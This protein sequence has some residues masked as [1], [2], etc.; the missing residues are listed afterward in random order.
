MRR[1][2]VLILMLIASVSV[3]KEGSILPFNAQVDTLPNGLKIV[4]VPTASKGIIV[5]YSIVRAGSR[6]EVEAG[7]TGFAHF[8]EHMMFRGTERYSSAEWGAKLASYGADTNAYTTYDYTAYF[9]VAPKT[10]LADLITL[11]SDR[12]MNLKYS[13]AGFRTE[14]G[15]VLGE[16]NKAKSQP[17]MSIRE[18]LAAAAFKRHTYGHTVI[19]L[20]ADIKA[21]PEGFAYAQTFFER[22]YT[23]DNTTILVVGDVD[24]ATLLPQIE[25]AYGPWKRT[26]TPSKITPEPAQTEPRSAHV[27]WPTPTPVYVTVAW[28]T[29]AFSTESVDC[30]ALEVA[31]ELLYGKTSPLYRR[32]VLTEQSVLGLS[33]TGGWFSRDPG[34]L[35]I[36][37][38]LKDATEPESI[39]NAITAAAASLASG[40]IDEKQLAAVKS[41]LR[42]RRLM[43]LDSP[44]AVAEYFVELIG[45]TGDPASGEAYLRQIMAVTSK[46]VARVAGAY[47]NAQGLTVVTLAPDTKPEVVK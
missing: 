34:L 38:T 28:K 27:T 42:Y 20:E 24:R 30:A 44:S 13:E 19:G 8:F 33:H 17:G 40:Q 29:P 12:F 39:Q 36:R 4:T 26:Y 6:D 43:S 23:P 5:Y 2:L 32:L 25:A 45:L 15:A 35:L 37:A 11:E 41:A 18:A 14:A 46:D 47:L 3:A 21:M 1:A 22:F 16:Y 31:A 7:K 9:A 10:A